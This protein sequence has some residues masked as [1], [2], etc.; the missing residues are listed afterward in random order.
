MST[1]SITINVADKCDICT[2]HHGMHC[3]IA[4]AAHDHPEV[5]SWSIYCPHCSP[6]C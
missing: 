5:G 4:H 6:W 3:L 1:S 2:P